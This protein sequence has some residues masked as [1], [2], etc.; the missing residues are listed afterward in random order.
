MQTSP[1]TATPSRP[2][3]PHPMDG[4]DYDHAS[5]NSCGDVFA[6]RPEPSR[7]HC[8]AVV[9]WLGDDG[10]AH[11][12]AL[13][14][15]GW[16]KFV[17]DDADLVV[18]GYLMV[19]PAIAACARVGAPVG[20]VLSLET[21][22]ATALEGR[23]PRLDPRRE[24]P[25]RVV[26]FDDVDQP[27]SRAA[28]TARAV[29]DG[30]RFLRAHAGK[31]VLVHCHVG[32]SRSTA[33]AYAMMADRLGPGREAEALARVVAVRPVATPNRLVVSLADAALGR[34]GDLVAALEAHPG[35]ARRRAG[36]EWP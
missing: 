8:G 24:P 33:M 30:L 4:Y 14:H 26:G 36:L 18:C 16:E 3:P 6:A 13:R 27:R 35:I 2:Y 5:C 9:A 28:P 11:G 20:A 22:G 17:A 25:Q 21:P 7:C 15:R 34:G 10:H 23:A 12:C 1:Q 32:L 19:R 31:K 29:E